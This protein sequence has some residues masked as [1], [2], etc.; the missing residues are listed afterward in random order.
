VSLVKFFGEDL[1]NRYQQLFAETLQAKNKQPP[2]HADDR[3]N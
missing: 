2:N 1:K 3:K